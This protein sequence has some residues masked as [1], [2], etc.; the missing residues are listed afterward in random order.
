M[1]EP[2]GGA[3]LFKNKSYKGE[4]MENSLYLSDQSIAMIAKLVQIA[5]LTGTDVVDNLRVLRLQVEDGKIE[6]DD[7]YLD[8]FEKTIQE[9][10]EV[11][12]HGQFN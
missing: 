11:S 8:E 4:N 2:P 3:P 6:P 10:L 9:M 7:S 5:I 12:N 1:E